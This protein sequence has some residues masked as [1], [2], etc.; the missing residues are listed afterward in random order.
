MAV[1]AA[2]HSG[3]LLRPLVI[4]PPRERFQKFFW[5]IRQRSAFFFHFWFLPVTG[6][7]D[8]YL[9][10]CSLE[11]QARAAAKAYGRFVNGKTCKE[12]ELR[13]AFH[14]WNAL[15][16]CNR[17]LRMHDLALEFYPATDRDA[18]IYFRF[19]YNSAAFLAKLSGRRL[20]RL[21]KL[22]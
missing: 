4:T 19:P 18:R 10:K 20:I 15:R 9:I 3:A 11:H 8:R 5:Q 14:A 17:F 7:R 2:G 13:L 12:H 16:K 21:N 22:Q 1:A 6:M